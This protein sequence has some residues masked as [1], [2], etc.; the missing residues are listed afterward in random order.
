MCHAVMSHRGA[1]MRRTVAILSL[2]FVSCATAPGVSTVGVAMRSVVA[3]EENRDDEWAAFCSGVVVAQ[4]TVLTNAHCVTDSDDIYIRALGSRTPVK[5]NAALKSDLPF[6][7]AVLHANLVG[8][9]E[10]SI[11]TS[12]VFAG[13]EVFAIGMPRGL[14]WSVTR[15]I[16]SAVDRYLELDEY[17]KNR[18]S[19]GPWLQTDA[20]TNHGNSGGPLFDANGMLIGIVTLKM[21]TAEGVGF[22]APSSEILRIAGEALRKRGCA[23]RG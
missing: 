11:R 4:N 13:E 8:V 14:R 21:L 6:D 15:G 2:L 17:E 20:A 9:P 22:A 23:C 16:V 3:L 19:A 10:A 5:A 12:T 18:F 1:A 7:V